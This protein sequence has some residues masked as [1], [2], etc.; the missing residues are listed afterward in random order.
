LSGETAPA[1]AFASCALSYMSLIVASKSSARQL[2]FDEF[3]H[4]FKERF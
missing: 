1:T 2:F 3:V 4:Q